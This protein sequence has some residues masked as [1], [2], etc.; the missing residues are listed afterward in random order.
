MPTIT[1]ETPREEYTIAGKTFHVHQPYAEGHVLTA[2]E[3]ASLNQTFAENIRNN[4]ASKVKAAH[5]AGSFD[6]D[7]F[8]TQLDEYMHSYEFG[9]RRSSG[10]GSTRAPADPVEA[11]ALL[12]AKDKVKQSLVKKG[13]A[14]KDVPASEITRLAK[15]VLDRK[16]ATA[17]AIRTAAAT[18]VA[19]RQDVADIELGE[20]QTTSS[21][22]AAPKPSKR[23][24]SVEA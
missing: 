5:E 10:G 21:E 24:A 18:R 12:I 22:D 6:H 14:L 3:A 19:A 9:V 7:A 8:Q 4:F 13:Y 23:K 16:D 1:A 17:E 20:V 15:D 11:E 2:G